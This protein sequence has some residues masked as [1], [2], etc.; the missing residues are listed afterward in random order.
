MNIFH[1]FVSI[2]GG[3]GGVLGKRMLNPEVL[4]CHE[5]LITLETYVQQGITMDI[6]FFICENINIFGYLGGPEGVF[7]G[8]TGPILL[9]SYPITHIYVHV[10]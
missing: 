2:W 9:S 5:D 8:Q 4:K 6:K 3:G 7:N 10:K 1:N